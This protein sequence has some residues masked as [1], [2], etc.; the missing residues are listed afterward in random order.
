[1]KPT[2]LYSNQPEIANI[3][4][5]RP[6]MRK[7]VKLITSWVSDGKTKVMGNKKMKGSQVYPERFGRE[8][9]RLWKA[10]RNNVLKRHTKL[11]RDASRAKVTVDLFKSPKGAAEM[12][13]DAKLTPCLN[14][15]KK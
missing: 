14:Y 6:V 13:P 12:W 5:S 3:D 8:V 10:S 11:L 1:M 4:Q 7:K 9:H 2:I 15:L